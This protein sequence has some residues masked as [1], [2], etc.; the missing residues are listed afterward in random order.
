MRRSLT[1]DCFH[2]SLNFA[3]QCEAFSGNDDVF[4]ASASKCSNETN[5][6]GRLSAGL[7]TG[8]V[9]STARLTRVAARRLCLSVSGRV[10][11]GRGQVAHF[12]HTRACI[13]PT[14]TARDSPSRGGAT[15]AAAARICQRVTC[16]R[17]A[18]KVRCRGAAHIWCP[19]S[20]PGERRGLDSVSR[21]LEAD[22]DSWKRRVLCCNPAQVAEYA[23][24]LA[25]PAAASSPMSSCGRRCF[26]PADRSGTV[27]PVRRAPS[28][29]RC[30]AVL[31]IS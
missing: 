4:L 30:P 8:C 24:N 10:F 15:Q 9:F 5:I 16:S 22:N 6:F 3:L 18:S 31:G 1:H 17:I 12:P 13:A 28:H 14:K 26:S 19:R 29:G 21:T 20:D 25:R 7:S 2:F 23:R 11:V 27:F